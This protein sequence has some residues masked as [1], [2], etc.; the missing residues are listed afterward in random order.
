MAHHI[1][2]EG[3]TPNRILICGERPGWDEAEEG[4]PFVGPAGQELWARLWRVCKLEREDVYVTNLVKTFSV[5]PPS[6]AEL[7]IWG[8]ILRAELLKVKPAIII[9]V[10]YHAARWFLP[11]FEDTN[12]EYFHGLAFP[13]EYGRLTRRH[14][15]VVPVVHSSA[16]LRQP[17]R[18]QQQLSDDLRA[19]A[20]V[21]A[22][23]RHLHRS[24]RSTPYQVGL[25]GFGRDGQILGM[26]SEY[27]DT[28]HGLD[29]EVVTLSHRAQESACLEITHNTPPKFLRS[30]LIFNKTIVSH[31]AK[32]EYHS[33][34]AL[35]LGEL[36]TDVRVDDT[37]LMAYL[38]NLPQSLKVL[39]YRE[40]G[41]EMQ[42]YADL[43]RPIDDARV[44]DTLRAWLTEQAEHHAYL[45]ARAARR[46]TRRT[47]DGTR[48]T[49]KAIME[50]Y[51]ADAA[52][53]TPTRVIAGLAR[54]LRSVS[55]EPL[56]DRWSKSV[57]APL[58]TLPP[59]ASWRDAPPEE[60]RSYA[61]TDS[62]AH[63]LAYRHLAPQ[64]RAQG[65]QQIYEI[66]RSQ[67]PILA[68]MEHIGMACDAKALEGLSRQFT[69]DFERTCT[70][71]N[72]LAG[73][74]VNP[75]SGEQVSD[76]LFHELGIRPTRLTKSQKHHTTADKY[77]KA[78]RNEHTI[79]PLVLSARQLNKYR[80]T[81]TDKLPSMLRDG[82][83]HM[84]WKYTRT[85]SGRLAEQVILL[86]PK[87]DPLAV[88]E[89]RA[90]R[91]Q[92]IRNAFHATEGH[93]LVSVD[94]SQI[95][96]R[97]MAHL[98]KDHHLLKAYAEGRDIHAQVA[99]ELLGAPREK[100]DQDESA[101]RLPA[102]TLNFGIINGMTEFG[103]LDQLH[104]AGQLQW[105]IESVRDLLKGWF[106]VH[107]GVD[108]FWKGEI[109]K[110]RRQ[111]YIT[112]LFGRRRYIAAVHSTNEQIRKEAERQCLGAIQSTA[113]G[114]SKIW[115]KKIWTRVIRPR[116]A[117]RR[118]YCE[119]WVRVHDDTTLETSTAIAKDVA[120]E[121]LALVPQVLCIPTTAEAKRGTQWGDL[122]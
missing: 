36:L 111:G 90:N 5:E 52:T 69:R 110:C 99:H 78:R 117:D 109:A 112:D 1:P 85:P 108:H 21:R 8:P 95:E 7:A 39:A 16:A 12:G 17:A 43:V 77:L 15:T 13:Y 18:Y 4:R 102:K 72:A 101:H 105:D 14:A 45:E 122:H 9:T 35:G 51:K 87:H 68:R 118:L 11:Q 42:E 97:T 94:L 25:A 33:A 41:I 57:N 86:I 103:I 79:I 65:L 75:L 88:K 23:R 6:K 61:M 71:I 54:M 84:D 96:L 20:D 55:E 58:V 106:T 28:P 48:V 74:P 40:L 29:V 76:C 62:I 26:D 100:K 98:A 2:G 27:R 89:K 22:D 50:Q 83:Y 82:R 59:P 32:A 70:Q 115:N 56:R 3:V 30:C 121:M 81:Y 120:A 119:P 37:M 64:I 67:L 114:I 60:R 49:K 63:R 38:L 24:G 116:H 10:G 34:Y 113:D 19:V 80:S 44:M 91:A 31:M 92:A 107:T 46:V 93:E 47:P 73:H 104:E 53:A 66:D